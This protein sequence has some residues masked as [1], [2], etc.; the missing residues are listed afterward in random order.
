[1]SKY[2]MVEELL[3]GVVSTYH[4]GE[5]TF[6]EEFERHCDVRAAEGLDPDPF[7]QEEIDDLTW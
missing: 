6:L 3:P 5:A 4:G 7:R 1:M 2:L